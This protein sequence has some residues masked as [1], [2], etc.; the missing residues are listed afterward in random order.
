MKT[1]YE[2]YLIVVQKGNRLFMCFFRGGST[3]EFWVSDS[4]YR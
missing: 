4:F 3:V 1:T 2:G